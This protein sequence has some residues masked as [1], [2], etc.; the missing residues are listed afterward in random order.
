VLRTPAAD[1][2]AGTPAWGSVPVVP[3]TPVGKPSPVFRKIEDEDVEA[4]LERL[5]GEAAGG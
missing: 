4:E 5:R 3:G 2:G 1:G